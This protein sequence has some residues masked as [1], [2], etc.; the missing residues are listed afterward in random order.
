M[1]VA[2]FSLPAA[3]LSSSSSEDSSLLKVFAS[4]SGV[5]DNGSSAG[6]AAFR[7]SEL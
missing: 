6:P 1:L 4:E 3:S 5:A 2:S 7:S